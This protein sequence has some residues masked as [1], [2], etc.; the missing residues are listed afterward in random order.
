MNGER[1]IAGIGDGEAGR[2]LRKLPRR[3]SRRLHLL[4]GMNFRWNLKGWK[5]MKWGRGR[6]E[7]EG[8]K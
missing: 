4:S 7:G 8:K 2:G 5:E 1:A 6:K 3:L